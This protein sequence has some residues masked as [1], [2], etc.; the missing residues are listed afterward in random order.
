MYESYKTVYTLYM[1]KKIYT[2]SEFRKR[3]REA[4]NLVDDLVDVY[5]DRYGVR[6][7][8]ITESYYKEILKPVETDNVTITKTDDW[9]A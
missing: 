9:G 1:D 5:I 3:T 8:L 4:F 6:Y 2:L 7:M